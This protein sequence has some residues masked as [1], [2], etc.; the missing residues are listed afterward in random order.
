MRPPACPAVVRAAWTIRAFTSPE[1]KK[2]RDFPPAFFL[3]AEHDRHGPMDKN[4]IRG[5][6]GRTSEQ[7]IAKSKSTKTGVVNPA[8]VRGRRSILPREISGV[9]GQPD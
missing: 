9:S 8:G 5:L 4:R 1:T 2:A 3:C 6:P 7:V